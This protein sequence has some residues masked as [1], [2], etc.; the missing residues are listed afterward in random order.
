MP[1]SPNEFSAWF[2]FW[3]ALLYAGL[4]VFSVVAVVVTLRGWQEIKAMLRKLKE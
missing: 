2:N 4:G 3:M 1:D